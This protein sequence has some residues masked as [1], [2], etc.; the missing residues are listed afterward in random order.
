MRTAISPPQPRPAAVLKATRG[1]SRAGN[2]VRRNPGAEAGSGTGWAGRCPSGRRPGKPI[3]L[4]PPRLTPSP[5]PPSSHRSPGSPANH[6]SL[7]SFGGGSV[8][9]LSPPQNSG[10]LTALGETQVSIS[11]C[12]FCSQDWR[13][14]SSNPQ[15]SHTFWGSPPSTLNRR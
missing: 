10:D 2:L 5:L 7:C 14:K 1:F 11:G 8:S 4:P 15:A 13:N 12:S 3:F 9:L 6:Q